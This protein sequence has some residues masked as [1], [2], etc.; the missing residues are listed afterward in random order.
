MLL[1]RSLLL[2][3]SLLVSRSWSRSVSLESRML[4]TRPFM[5]RRRYLGVDAT[6]PDCPSESRSCGAAG[7][8][9]LARR[10]LGGRLGSCLGL[11]LRSGECVSLS[12]RGT[13]EKLSAI[14]R[15]HDFCSFH[16]QLM[17]KSVVLLSLHI[18][19]SMHHHLLLDD[20]LVLGVNGTG[21]FG[22]FSDMTIRGLVVDHCDIFGR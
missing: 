7:F 16:H 6:R 4:R 9:E 5:D 2:S 10:G 8:R 1:S 17:L 11:S 3:W 19:R 15:F 13:V 14:V 12:E 20:I 22:M 21:E 18:L